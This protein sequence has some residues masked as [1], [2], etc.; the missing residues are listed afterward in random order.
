[1]REERVKTS[2]GRARVDWFPAARHRAT[3]VLGHGT[4]T[5][6]EA[7]DLQALAH[8]LPARGVTVA[9][10]TQPYRIEHNPAV[11][12]PAFL[13]RAWAAVWARI[14]AVTGPGPNSG[15]R[16]EGSRRSP[17]PGPVCGR[18]QYAYCAASARL[19][20]KRSM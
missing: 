9:L 18:V 13:D 10:V 17:P 16:T 12:D 20:A 3:L 7:A 2:V 5:G 1:M 14:T 15:R 6:V 4:A 11:A 8:A 19:G